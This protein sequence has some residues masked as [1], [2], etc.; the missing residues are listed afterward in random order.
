MAWHLVSLSALGIQT[1]REI[2]RTLHRLREVLTPSSPGSI[3]SCRSGFV[4]RGR[5]QQMGSGI[6]FAE[7]KAQPVQCRLSISATS[8]PQYQPSD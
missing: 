8:D 2:S 7:G 6:G 5:Q 3:T 4:L 1:R